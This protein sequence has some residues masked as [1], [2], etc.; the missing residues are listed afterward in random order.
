MALRVGLDVPPPSLKLWR[1]G[2]QAAS[3]SGTQAN[4]KNFPG[5][6]SRSGAIIAMIVFFI[7]NS[8]CVHHGFTRVG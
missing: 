6:H 7:K 1:T 4:Q 2:G 3:R 5:P 8:R